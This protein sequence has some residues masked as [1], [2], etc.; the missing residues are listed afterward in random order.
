MELTTILAIVIAVPVVLIP[1]ALVWY[2]NVSGTFAVIRDLQ[3]KRA[4]A[5]KWRTCLLVLSF[6]VV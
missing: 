5:K 6:K 4:R 2:M 1:L 3:R